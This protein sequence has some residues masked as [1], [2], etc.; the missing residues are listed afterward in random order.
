MCVF[1]DFFFF[2]SILTLHLQ[3]FYISV[4]TDV[5]CSDKIDTGWKLVTNFHIGDQNS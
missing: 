5:P 3:T 2:F 4:N 1:S